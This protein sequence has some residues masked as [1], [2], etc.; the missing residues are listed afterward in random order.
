MKYG[1]YA[2][3]DNLVGFQSPYLQA[4]RDV[5]LRSFTYAARSPEKNPVNEHPENMELWFLGVFDSESG[6]FETDKTLPKLVASA[7]SVIKPDEVK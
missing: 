2:L 3:K 6:T 5:A 7:L 1:V 4:N